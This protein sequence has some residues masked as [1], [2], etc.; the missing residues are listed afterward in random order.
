MLSGWML[1]SVGYSWFFGSICLR[2]FG[3]CLLVLKRYQF[4]QNAIFKLHDAGWLFLFCF[5]VLSMIQAVCVTLGAV[6]WWLRT[7]NFHKLFL[8]FVLWGWLAVSVCHVLCVYDPSCM[9]H[10]GSCLL[11]LRSNQYTQKIISKFHFI[12]LGGC[13]WWPHTV[14]SLAHYVSAIV[15]AVC[16]CLKDTSLQKI[17]FSNFNLWGWLLVVVC[18]VLFSQCFKLYVSLWISSAGAWELPVYTH[19]QFQISCYDAGRLFVFVMHCFLY[20]STRLCHSGSFLLV[21]NNYNFTQHPMPKCH[22]ITLDACLCL[23]LI[24]FCLTQCVFAILEAV[25]W[26]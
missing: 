17:P 23:P 24:V 18:H 12:K 11:V 5:N 9:C 2:P 6:C 19:C 20:D 13:F 25:C 16:G 22:F 26:R 10:S 3:G 15:E 21:V 8:R 7:I 4:T 1:A 14:F